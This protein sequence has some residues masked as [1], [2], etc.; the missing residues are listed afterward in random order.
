MTKHA[1]LQDTL[2]GHVC[3]IPFE[4][5]DDKLPGKEVVGAKAYNL[6]RIARRGLSIPPAFVLTTSLCRDY[7]KN[8][9]AALEG[10]D[11]VLD[12][13]LTW[14]GTIAGRHFGDPRCPRCSSRFARALRSRCRA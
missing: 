9:P 2:A 7:L 8:G 10:L 11:E 6:M 14:L 12:R 13:E 4:G 5:A 3:R 1:A